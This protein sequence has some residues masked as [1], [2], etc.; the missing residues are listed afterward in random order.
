MTVSV[1][2]ISVIFIAVAIDDLNN[3]DGSIDWSKVAL[4][5]KFEKI[6]NENKDLRQ[7]LND[8]TDKKQQIEEIIKMQDGKLR[9]SSDQ[10]NLQ[11]DLLTKENE[12]L[13][14]EN[15]EDKRE[16]WYLQQEA[17]MFIF[18][19]IGIVTSI[20]IL[21]FI[22]FKVF[23]RRWCCCHNQSHRKYTRLNTIPEEI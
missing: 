4:Q 11:I 19:S 20:L 16:I 1:V 23:G 7:K 2:L 9:S 13:T 3:I 14:E 22:S 12:V 18:A 15:I 17:K 5:E 21:N 6:F 10:L 8:M